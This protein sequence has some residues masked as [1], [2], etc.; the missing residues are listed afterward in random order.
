MMDIG[1]KIDDS[2]MNYDFNFE[3]YGFEY[4]NVSEIL[5][6]KFEHS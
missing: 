2:G 3:Q 6:V 4:S 1:G 5:L